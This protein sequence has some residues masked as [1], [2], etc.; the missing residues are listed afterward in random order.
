MQPRPRKRCGTT[1]AAMGY[2]LHISRPQD[3][4][5]AAEQIGRGAN[6]SSWTLRVGASKSRS[7]SCDCR[8]DHQNCACPPLRPMLCPTPPSARASSAR[9]VSFVQRRGRF[10]TA[11][12]CTVLSSNVN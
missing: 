1:D 9:H 8:H 11:V 6:A 3:E 5:K 7:R 12:P 10:Q 4:A 2:K